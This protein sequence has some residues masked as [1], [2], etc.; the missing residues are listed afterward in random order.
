M[1]D[2]QVDFDDPKGSP[3]VPGGEEVVAAGNQKIERARE[4]AHSTLE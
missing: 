3:Y 1:V 2:V 4:A